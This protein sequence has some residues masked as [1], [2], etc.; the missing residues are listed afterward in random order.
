MKK[1]KISLQQTHGGMYRVEKMVNSARY[2]SCSINK[3]NLV[4]QVGEY[5]SQAQTERLCDD[6]CVEVSVFAVK[7]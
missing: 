5:L 1:I 2:S 6:G 4:V 7:N 3:P